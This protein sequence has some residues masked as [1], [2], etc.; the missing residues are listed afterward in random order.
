MRHMNT[1]GFVVTETIAQKGTN[2]GGV[3]AR[4]GDSGWE[5]YA[6]ARYHYAWSPVMSTSFIPV[7]FGIPI[8]LARPHGP[9]YRL[10][11]TRILDY[12]ECATSPSSVHHNRCAP[13]AVLFQRVDS[14]GSYSWWIL[15]VYRARHFRFDPSF[16]GSLACH[17]GRIIGEGLQPH[18][19]C[20]RS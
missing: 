5:F 2:A 19:L 15:D 9:F 7:T 16:K 12:P 13:F 1:V 8:Q 11:G 14:N 20:C 17:R 4:F 18:R 6:E 3:N 10:G